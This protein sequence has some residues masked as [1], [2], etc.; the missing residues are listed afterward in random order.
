M[1]I[2]LGGSGTVRVTKEGLHCEQGFTNVSKGVTTVR[3]KVGS[4]RNG[5]VN[6]VVSNGEVT[7]SGDVLVVDG[8]RHT[9]VM[10]DGKRVFLPD[11]ERFRAYRTLNQETDVQTVIE[12]DATT[13]TEVVLSGQVHLEADK[14]PS[15][16]KVTL[17]GQAH[18][19]CRDR[20]TVLPNLTVDCSGQSQFTGGWDIEQATLCSSGQ[21]MIQLTGT[22]LTEAVV[23]ASGMSTIIG[24]KG[25]SCSLSKE[26]GQMCTVSFT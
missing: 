23:D 3:A 12:C 17:S 6:S 11:T 9:R 1:K 18:F 2:E 26:K 8:V 4:G 15:V 22:V 13:I 5:F 25:R 20:S 10:V 7:I 14:L 19:V 24:R 16:Q 21:S